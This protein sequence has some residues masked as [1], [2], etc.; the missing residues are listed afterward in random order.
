[1]KQLSLLDYHLQSESQNII[2]YKGVFS[3]N[4]LSKISMNIR[5]QLSTSRQVAKRVFS[6][7]L[8]LGQNV[9]LYSAE[10]NNFGDGK[11]EHGV[12]V[13][14]LDERNDAFVLTVGNLILQRKKKEIIGRIERINK[15]NEQELRKLKIEQRGMP[16]AEGQGGANI[17][18]IHVA[19]QSGKP[20]TYEIQDMDDEFAFLILHVGVDK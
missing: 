12:G 3:A 15:L 5:K 7:F 11:E 16:R 1:M 14:M 4:I 6:I 20:F 18:L 2:Y 8:E 19:L 9:A 17:G 13:L 10:S